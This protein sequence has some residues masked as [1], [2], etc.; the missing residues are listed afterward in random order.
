MCNNGRVQLQPGSHNTPPPPLV[1]AAHRI[2]THSPP[3]SSPHSHAVI[4]IAT[5][6]HPLHTCHHVYHHTTDPSFMQL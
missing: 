3:R 6:L 1:S 4:V 2:L 5:Q